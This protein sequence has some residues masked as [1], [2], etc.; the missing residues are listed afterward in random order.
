MPSFLSSHDKIEVKEQLQNGLTLQNT[1]AMLRATI[2]WIRS[3]LTSLLTFINFTISTLMDDIDAITDH[4]AVLE[5]TTT[6]KPI[7]EQATAST[8]TP[9]QPLC[10][11]TQ[12]RCK[13]Y[14]TL[15]HTT[16]DCCTKDPAAI[17]K[18]VGHNQKE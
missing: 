12:T 4:I 9:V 8:A 5:M 7:C 10:P 3:I 13:H 1:P 6:T 11:S 17:K 14:H 2:D 15:G 18:R 16:D